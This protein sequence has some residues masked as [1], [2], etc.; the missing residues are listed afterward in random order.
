MD[1]S[2]RSI[3]FT[4]E[5]EN[6]LLEWYKDNKAVLEQ[7][8]KGQSMDERHG[9]GEC[10]RDFKAKHVRY[11]KAATQRQAQHQEEGVCE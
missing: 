9:K 3:K 7:V 8:S 6:C 1:S 11:K 4:V 10:A 2:T 5:E